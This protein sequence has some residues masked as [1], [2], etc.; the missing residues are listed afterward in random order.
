M[1]LSKKHFVRI[2]DDINKRI[3]FIRTNSNLL[4]DE[5]ATCEQAMELVATDLARFF[6]EESDNFKRSVF[7]KACGF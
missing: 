3:T 7:L 1:A 2:S 4:K 5:I 6:E